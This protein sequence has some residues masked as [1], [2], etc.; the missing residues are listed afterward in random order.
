ML[1]KWLVQEVFLSAYY[2]FIKIPFFL[3]LI[4]SSFEFK[5]RGIHNF[6]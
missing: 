1:A 4:V 5:P 2:T 3:S 6:F